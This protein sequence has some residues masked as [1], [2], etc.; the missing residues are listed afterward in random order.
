MGDLWVVTRSPPPTK[1]NLPRAPRPNLCAAAP[2]INHRFAREAFDHGQAWLSNTGGVWFVAK[3]SSERKRP[4]G[5]H[6]G[7]H[8]DVSCYSSR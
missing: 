3:S 7:C 4:V 8:G 5:K 6:V 1:V 2:P